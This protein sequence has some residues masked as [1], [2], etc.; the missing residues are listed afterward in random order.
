MHAAPSTSS[1]ALGWGL[2]GALVLIVAVS[3]A[4]RLIDGGN[5][6]ARG[7]ILFEL[8]MGMSLIGAPG[9]GASVGPRL[10]LAVRIGLAAAMALWLSV[11]VNTIADSARSGAIPLD[12][13]QTTWR[14]ARLLLRGENPYGFGALVDFQAFDDR[15]AQREAAGIG[16][17]IPRAQFESALRAYDATLAAPERA[18]LLPTPASAPA[19][20]EAHLLGYKYG[21]LFPL[22][23]LPLVALHAPAGVMALNALVAALTLATLYAMLRQRA[24][25]S[26]AQLGLAALLCDNTI[27]FN[28]VMLS[29]TDIYALLFCAL[30][31]WAMT[32]ER[33]NWAAMVLAIGFGFKIFPCALL[34]PMLLQR[35]RVKPALIFA[36]F[37]GAIYL[38]SAVADLSGLLH[39]VFLWPAFLGPE[40]DIVAWLRPAGGQA[41]RPRRW[42]CRHR[43]AMDALPRRKRAEPVPRARPGRAGGSRHQ[44]NFP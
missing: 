9:A 1:R 7:L 36:A 34:F 3:F 41:H 31:V 35:G 8:L 25:A 37:A 12:Q 4:F 39:N 10:R 19:A 13:G 16:P 42:P 21:P 29:A 43:L 32:R 5:G 40:L 14:A 23:A 24:G 38:P 28:Y 44:R 22:L 11:A 26:L 27:L 6:P 30:S 33:P 18:A 20:L 17:Q 2:A 15:L